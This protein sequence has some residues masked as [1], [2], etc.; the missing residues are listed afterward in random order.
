MYKSV[1][2]GGRPVAPY[3]RYT[4]IYDGVV[5]VLS[6]DHPEL[7]ITALCVAQC[8]GDKLYV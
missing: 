7:A 5:S 4:A 1:G 3:V 2:P 8:C 6:R